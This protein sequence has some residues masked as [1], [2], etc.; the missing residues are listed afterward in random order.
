M[1]MRHAQIKQ[2]ARTPFDVHTSLV[3]RLRSFGTQVNFPKCIY[4][5]KIHHAL[6]QPER[7]PPQASGYPPRGIASLRL[8]QGSLQTT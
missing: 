7:R 1:V 2:S 3:E 6:L 4:Q 5:D 8:L